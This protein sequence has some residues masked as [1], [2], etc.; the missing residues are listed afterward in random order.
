MP[1]MTME[2]DFFKCASRKIKF[3]GKARP[4]IK[5]Q[6]IACHAIVS[7]TE[8]KSVQYGINYVK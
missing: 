1:H 5:G 7:S 3:G 2:R 6:G 8:G 4:G